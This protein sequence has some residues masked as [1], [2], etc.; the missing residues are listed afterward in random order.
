MSESLSSAASYISLFCVPPEDQ[1]KQ[2]PF[3]E[4]RTVLGG[5]FDR[6]RISGDKRLYI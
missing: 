2:L 6:F 3:L 5:D 1:M 4:A